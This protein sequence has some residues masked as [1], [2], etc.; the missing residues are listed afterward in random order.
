M[1]HIWTL[2]SLILLIKNIWKTIGLLASKR[3]KCGEIS[4]SY[5]KNHRNWSPSEL[6]A[7]SLFTNFKNCSFKQCIMQD[8]ADKR[9]DET[10]DCTGAVHNKNYFCEETGLGHFVFILARCALLS[11]AKIPARK[12]SNFCDFWKK[13][14]LLISPHFSPFWLKQTFFFLCLIRSP[15][16]NMC[17]NMNHFIALG[18]SVYHSEEVINFFWCCVYLED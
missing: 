4:E 10:L 17:P 16:A 3:R 14:S 12:A 15:I 1:N 9:Q 6:H 7:G 18:F 2:I 11:V 8:N 13:W 5:F